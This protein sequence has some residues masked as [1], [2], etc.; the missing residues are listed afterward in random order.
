VD[1]LPQ[2]LKKVFKKSRH[3]LLGFFSHFLKNTFLKKYLK[4]QDTEEI[5]ADKDLVYSLT[6]SKIPRREQFKYLFSFFNPRERII[7]KIA[8]LILLASLAYLTIGFYNNNLITLP[9]SG[10][11]YREGSASYPQS[12]NP[13]YASARDIDSDLA[14]LIYSSL[15]SYDE[16]GRLRSDLVE[17][18]QSSADG[19]EYSFKLRENVKWHNGNILTIEDVVFTFNLIKNPDFRSPLRTSL[20]GI[21]I[22]KI[23]DFNFRL[24]LAEPYADLLHLLTFGIMPRFAWESV[25][26]EAAIISELNLKAIGSGPYQ[27]DSLVKS[28]GGEMKEYH[29]V[30]NSD[31]YGPKPYINKIVFKFFPDYNQVLRALNSNEIEGASY[32]PEDLLSDV[33]ARHS[34]N[35]H[36]LKLPQINSIFFNQVKSDF[37]KDIKVRQ[38]LNY[39]IDRETLF[40]EVL[41]LG[42]FRVDGPILSPDFAKDFGQEI[43]NLDL[44]KARELLRE[45][46]FKNI[47]STEAD[48]VAEE[49]SAEIE[50]INKYSQEKNL[51]KIDSWW[52]SENNQI[53]QFRFLVSL[54]A[55]NELVSLLQKNW[56][57]FGVRIFVEQVS[58]E[59]VLN[60][61]SENDFDLLFYGQA[62]DMDPD[63]AAFWHSSQIG[64]GS[65]NITSYKN[66]EVDSL[67][68]EARQATNFDERFQKYDK[69]QQIIIADLPAIFLYSPSYIYIQDKK[70]RGFSVSF[71]SSPSDRFANINNWYLSTKKRFNW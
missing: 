39:A 68:I 21:N 34:L 35:F 3:L 38:A 25:I 10:G 36:Y 28:K 62:V 67:L 8:I 14:R 64:D 19:K 24:I 40:D 71:I 12:I 23:D 47:V 13:L 54:N 55:K 17:S 44:E 63:I 48:F 51:N 5:N 7:F 41:S 50:A 53:L 16:T 61:L 57:D 31:Y 33:L 70:V 43:Y 4:N 1:S 59:D 20:S 2:Q 9:K 6:A 65:F 69:V 42:G 52:L 56:E 58:N 27:F 46:G 30:V 11:V 66:K 49:L 45:A 37:L 32:L 60:K 15:F 26:A 29:L 22:E 18:W